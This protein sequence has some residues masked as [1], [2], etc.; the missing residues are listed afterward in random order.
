M[1]KASVLRFIS[2]LIGKNS[3]EQQK[4]NA[5]IPEL[6]YAKIFQVI[7]EKLELMRIKTK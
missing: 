6:W 1:K 5:M 4:F 7:F 3:R 2:L